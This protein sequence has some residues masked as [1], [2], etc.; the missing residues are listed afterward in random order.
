ME[1]VV[2]KLGGSILKNLHSSFYAQC[3]QLKQK[4]ISPVIIHGGGPMI[5]EWMEATGKH[6]RF[7]DGRRVTDEETL[8]IAEMVLAGSVN[9]Q[10]VTQLSS[11]GVTALGLSGIDLH[12]LQARE[13]DPRLGYV[14]E[15]VSVNGEVIL[16]LLQ[17]GWTPVIAS[18]G[19]DANGQHFNINAD[20]AAGAIAQAI[21]ARQLIMVSDV[22][23]IYGEDGILTHATPSLLE[24][25]IESGI[26]TGG[27][28]PKVRSGIKCLQGTVEEVVI[29]NGA[30]ADWFS[31]DSSKIQV[32]TRLVKEEVTEHVSI[33]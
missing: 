6:P 24:Q 26:I 14:G 29:I 1:T 22:D 28:I 8:S 32:G 31:E 9:K 30:K 20:E 10:I 33:S 23:G 17:Q 5:S 13:R 21:G 3:Y 19:T 12:L 15:I 16:H 27:M 7:V 11:A 2:I 25:Y 4:G 18:L